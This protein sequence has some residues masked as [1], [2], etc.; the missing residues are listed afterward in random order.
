MIL[1]EIKL[2][3]VMGVSRLKLM[4][5][6]PGTFN[7]TLHTQAFN[8]PIVTHGD[9]R[10]VFTVLTR[11]IKAFL[12][13]QAALQAYFGAPHQARLKALGQGADTRKLIRDVFGFNSTKQLTLLRITRKLNPQQFFTVVWMDN[14]VKVF[15]WDKDHTSETT[16][17]TRYSVAH[18]ATLDGFIKNLKHWIR[19]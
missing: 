6:T 9:L 19:E 13:K 7:L 14:Q 3:G 16:P 11:T 2:R 15:Q 17:Y 18:Y 12:P 1:T 8:A 10:R 4:E 5:L